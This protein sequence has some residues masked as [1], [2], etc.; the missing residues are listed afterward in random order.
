M[1]LFYNPFSKKPKIWIYIFLGILPIVLV[2][3]FIVGI[4]GYVQK[5][6]SEKLQQ[7]QSA[8][9]FEKF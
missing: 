2:V 5:K 4:Q 3:V 6:K 9:I 8:D 1:T 7:N